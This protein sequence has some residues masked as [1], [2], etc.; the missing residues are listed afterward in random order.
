MLL[1][2]GQQTVLVGGELAGELAVPPAGGVGGEAYDRGRAAEVEEIDAPAPSLE[3]PQT[4]VQA[5]AAQGHPEEGRV[6]GGMVFRDE[7]APEL[8]DEIRPEQGGVGEGLQKE[9]RPTA[10]NRGGKVGTV[11]AARRADREVA[12]ARK[13]RIHVDR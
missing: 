3:S 4:C 9:G 2:P 11:H 13:G 1:V 5:P 8:P 7:P 10:E 12:E 6:G